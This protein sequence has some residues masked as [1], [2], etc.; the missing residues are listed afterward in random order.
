M[1]IFDIPRTLILMRVMLENA[2]MTVIDP[3]LHVNI[4][5][6]GLVYQVKLDDMNML[7][8]VEMTLSSP[9]CPMSESIVSSVKNAL[10]RVAP[11]YRTEVSLV[12]DPVWN[13]DSISEEGLKQLN[14]S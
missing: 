11:D 12:W 14:G 13:Y 9:H 4:V 8:E 2:L 3:E 7:I 5:D 6:L 10:G 1:I